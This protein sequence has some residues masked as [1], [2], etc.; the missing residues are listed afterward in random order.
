[1]NKVKLVMLLANTPLSCSFLLNKLICKHNKNVI[2]ALP[3]SIYTRQ[4]FA[5]VLIKYI[6]VQLMKV[7]VWSCVSDHFKTISITCPLR[8]S[9]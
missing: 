5:F 3:N 1:M 7:P 8:C 6:F 2:S 4:S 9:L